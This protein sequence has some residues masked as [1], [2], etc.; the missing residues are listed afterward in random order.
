MRRAFLMVGLCT[1]ASAVASACMT[2]PIASTE[3][4]TSNLFVAP[5]HN[6][7][8]NKIDLLFMIDNSSSMGDKQKLLA[9]AVPQLVDRLVV[10]RC[11]GEHGETHTRTNLTE[12]CPENT[13]P[14]FRA[15]RDIHVAVITS[16][17]GSHGARDG[18]SCAPDAE[19]HMLAE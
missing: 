5:I 8:I 10:P 12:A 1:I 13:S 14:E 19:K 15:V 17:L 3:P 4:H 16:S 9:Q 11:V 2:R 18:S 7:V 6:E